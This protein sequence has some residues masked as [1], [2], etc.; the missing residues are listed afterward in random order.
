[1]AA[2]KDVNRSF[3]GDGEDVAAKIWS[4]REFTK[5]YSVN[6]LTEDG[7]VERMTTTAG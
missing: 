4:D 6:R 3:S 2:Q 5:G 7:I 1:M